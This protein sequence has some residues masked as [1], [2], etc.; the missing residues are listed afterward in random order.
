MTTLDIY[1]QLRPV[2][3]YPDRITMITIDELDI[4]T[5]VNS[6]I[7]SDFSAIACLMEDLKELSQLELIWVDGGY[8]ARKF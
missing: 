8:K 1:F 6:P 3:N 7:G 2:I 4:K 5:S